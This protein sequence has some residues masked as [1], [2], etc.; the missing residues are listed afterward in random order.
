[1]SSILRR[2]VSI[3]GAKVISLLLG[4]VITP[5]LVRILGSSLYGDYAFLLSVLGVTMILV[6]AGIFDGVRKYMAEPRT[7]D[8]W[9]EHVFGFY[10]RVAITLAATASIGYGLLSWSGYVSMI[11]GRE[12]GLYLYL[13]AGLIV[14]RQLH[15]LT[16]GGL[17]GLGLESRSE[18]LAILK[19]IL[20]GIF[21]V[22][23]AYLDYGVAG[24]LLG[25][26]I[27]S[28]AVASIALVLLSQRLDLRKVFNEIPAKFPRRELFAYNGL[29]VVLILLTASL[30]HTDILFLRYL[31]GSQQTGYYKAALVIAEFLWFVPNALQTVLL[32]SSSELWTSDRKDRVSELAS[33]TT[34]YNLSLSL[35]LILGLAALAN[36][37][38]P[39]YFGAEF[40]STVEPL[41][42]LLP[43]ALGFALARPI[44]AVGQGKG[45]LRRLITATGS[46]ATLNLIL[47]VILIPRYGMI[48]AATATSV[49]YGSM[50]L[51]HLWAARSIGFDPLED[52]RITGIAA[53]VILTAP[54]IFGSAVVIDS[55]VL[56]L[57]VVPPTG[58]I[59][60]AVLTIKLGVVPSDELIP[61]VDRLPS[62][63]SLYAQKVLTY[64]E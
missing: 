52:I 26:I 20:F 59:V 24:V 35:L 34:R 55:A 6:N 48:G 2:F 54:V 25:H 15:S 28:L 40:N 60:Y 14:T 43:G 39:V 1:V 17:M 31:S 37:F 23:L 49:G 9:E 29:S 12:F 36:D 30:Y 63:A 61:I 13:L 38:V 7:D 5:V 51:L 57:L 42:I 16:R 11:F 22:S 8:G 4:L 45:E 3:F 53:V 50:F 27:A 58:F 47:N 44:F 64:L 32:H 46:A 56:S 33:R 19:K 21:G 62:S 18:P 10:L 41:L